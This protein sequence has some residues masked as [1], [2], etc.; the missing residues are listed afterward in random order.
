MLFSNPAFLWGLQAVLIPVAVHLFNFRRYRKEYF[1]NVEQLVELQT[2]SR[3]QNNLRQWLVLA[4][5]VL[6]IVFL[7][8]AF[9]RP[10]LRSSGA[11]AGEMS[12]AVVS[13][14]VENSFSMESADRDGS[15]LETA[16]QKA[17]EVADA[18]DPGTRF[19]LLTNSMD[20]GEMRWL[21]RDEL[22]EALEAVKVAPGSRLMS[23]VAARQADFM[24]NNAHNGKA[25]HHAY[26]ISD[27]QE[28]VTDIDALPADSTVLFTLVPLSGV[29][30]DNLYI[31]TVQLD[32]PA[33]FTGG[34]VNV[35]V[36][37]RNSGSRAAEKVPV[38]LYID[39]KERALTTLD[40]AE[41]TSG[42]ATLRFS[43]ERAGW[44]DGRVE[45]EDYPVTF[46]D[47]YHFT[48]LAGE[49]V[50]MAEVD[51]AEANTYLKKLF[52]ADEAVNYHSM[53]HLPPTVEEY[54]FI[55]F[56]EVKSLTSGE[57]QQ[58]TEWVSEGGSLLVVP[59]ADGAE[60]LNPLLTALQAP[61]LSRWVKRPVRA[62][63]IDYGSSLYRGVFSGRNDEMEMP[64]VQGH[65]SLESQTAVKQSIIG[66]ADGGELLTLTPWKEGKV[67]LF[68]TPLTADWTDL[69]S[70]ALF[71]PTLYNM[72]LYSRPLPP[73]SHTLGDGEP[74][75]LQGSYDLE[76]DL[77][78]LTD[79]EDLRLIPDLRRVGNRQV[80]VPHGELTS[81]GLYRL[82]DEHLAFNYDRR[83]SEMTFL[84]REELSQRLKGRPEYT[85]VRNSQK[86]LGEELRQRD[87]GRQLWRLCVLLA[88]AA[89]AAETA[90]L[91]L[92][93]RK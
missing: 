10:V 78:E 21:N 93:V 60:G 25:A 56:N 39:N 58:L 24:R 74:I 62:S 31:D 6:A 73:A 46:D 27:F 2:E 72:A 44:V 23:E 18:Y 66:L 75:V 57:M 13:L 83:E 42:T 48:L 65:F 77:P 33:Y 3:R 35:G 26:L 70:Q 53:S 30:A 9:A 51:G 38:K 8:L 50:G 52:D 7:V 59:P 91:K 14:Y 68:T 47:S 49:P 76:R 34:S 15:R 81:A 87:G 37:L 29:E 92:K 32:A 17:R 85:L 63:Q 16:K 11:H 54:S 86:P 90:L 4:A 64:T 55:V 5:R 84:S 71:V 12:G 36:T 80:M 82:A 89:L 40:L 43:I 61:A 67:Y 41:N 20:G 28:T 69:V 45:I 22:T 88:L 79:G 19:Q 1:S